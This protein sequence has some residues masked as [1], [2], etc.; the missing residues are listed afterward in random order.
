M[1]SHISFLIG[2]GAHAETRV[3]LRV[4]G[5]VVRTAQGRDFYAAVS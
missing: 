4:D 1:A 5:K 3:D 2:G